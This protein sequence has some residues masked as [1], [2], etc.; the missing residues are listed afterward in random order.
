MAIREGDWE[1]DHEL[2]IIGV[3]YVW[4]RWNGR[5]LTIRTDYPVDSILEA[6]KAEFN[7]GTGQRW[8]EMSKV[9]SIPVGLLYNEKLGLNEAFKQQDLPYLRRF[10][11]DSDN[12]ALRTREG[13]I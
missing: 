8:G 13:T 11:N 4:K 6:N 10:L 3:R 7:S 12:Q 2:S 1:L 5:E 9:A